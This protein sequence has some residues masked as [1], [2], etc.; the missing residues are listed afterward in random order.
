MGEI[1]GKIKNEGMK[2]FE[3][4]KHWL[5]QFKG[6]GTVAQE[7]RFR[8]TLVDRISNSVIFC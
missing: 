5:F 1:R 7:K 2:E 3:R 6:V 4:L 8:F